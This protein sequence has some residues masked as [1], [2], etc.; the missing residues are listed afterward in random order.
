MAEELMFNLEDINISEESLDFISEEHVAEQGSGSPEPAENNENAEGTSTDENLTLSD[1]TDDNNNNTVESETGDEGTENTSQED[2]PSSDNNSS[3]DSTLNALAQ[4]LKEEGVLFI[5]EELKDVKSLA[6]LK[7]LIKNSNEKARYANLNESQRRYQEALENG[8]PKSEFE[9]VEKEIQTFANIK[10]QDI[11]E[12]TN[13]RYEII[14]IDLI[15]Q[16]IEQNKAMKLAKLS[17]ADD[18]NVQDAKEALNNII[19]AKK[20]KFNTLVENNKKTHELKIDEVKKNVF[21]KEE[22][23]NTKLNDMTKNK[24]FDQITTKVDSDEEGRP[25]NELQKW[26]RD[27]PVESSIMLNYLYMMTNKGKDFNLIKQSA[28]STAA[29]D[30]ER[31]L[32]NMSFDKDGSLIIPDQMVRGGNRT[33]NTE[34]NNNDNLT[35]NI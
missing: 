12:N 1:T 34:D 9:E 8:V 11:V 30:L 13:L 7:D 18:T 16:G 28:G 25:L 23:L 29:K 2:T 6:D 27:N 24:L 19:E 15:N 4:Y 32:R 35:I 14:A 5:E 22:L 3:H 21:S 33:N 26:Q 17:L 10:E 31:K 20:T